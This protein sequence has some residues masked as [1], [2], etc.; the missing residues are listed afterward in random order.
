MPDNLEGDDGYLLFK[1]EEGEEY[2]MLP[3]EGD[4]VF[5]P[6]SLSHM[7]KT[8]IKSKLERIVCTIW[9]LLQILIAWI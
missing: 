8:N 1:T 5:F 2:K 6:A 4:L 7:P 3:K 9:S